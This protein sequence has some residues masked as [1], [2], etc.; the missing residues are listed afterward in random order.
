MVEKF[1]KMLEKGQ[2]EYKLKM[3]E[4]KRGKKKHKSDEQKKCI[5]QYWK[6][7]WLTRRC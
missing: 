3:N 7:L 1:Y 6:S 4:E 2:N 5:I